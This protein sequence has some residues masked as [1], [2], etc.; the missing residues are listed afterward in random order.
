MIIEFKEN[1]KLYRDIILFLFFM[2]FALRIYQ[3][4]I[5]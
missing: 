1:V 2:Y 5:H 4:Y 3:D